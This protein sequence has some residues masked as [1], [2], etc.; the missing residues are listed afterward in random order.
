MQA[1]Q[2]ILVVEQALHL[3]TPPVDAFGGRFGLL[4]AATGV[5]LRPIIAPWP[6]CFQG[7]VWYCQRGS[8]IVN[9]A[10]SSRL[11]GKTLISMGS[12]PGGASRHPRR[13]SGRRSRAGR[14]PR[15]NPHG[16]SA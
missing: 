11:L 6:R 8:R 1:G 4:I 12:A 14:A 16:A 9:I 5:S 10:P 15:W 2:E 7:V 13:L 3:V